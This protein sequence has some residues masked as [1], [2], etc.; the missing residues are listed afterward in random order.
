MSPVDE[1]GPAGVVA[2]IAN[3]AATAGSAGGIAAGEA[4]AAAGEVESAAELLRF[5]ARPE[6][7]RLWPEVRGRLERRGEA[8][9]T[10]RIDGATAAERRAVAGLLGLATVPEA[11][12]LRVRLER[13]DQALRA[14]RFAV[15]LAGAMALLGGPLRDRAAESARE[16]RLREEM[17]EGAAAH[18]A[19]QAR[20]DLGRWLEEL[21]AA[22]LV[23]R[24]ARAGEEARLL[25]RALDVL[26]AVARGR[27][28]MRLQVLASATLGASHGLDAGRPVASLVVRGLAFL[29]GQ[30]PP[31]GAAERRACWERAGV[32]VD[33]LSCNVLAL[34]VAPLGG[35]RAGDGLRTLAA[36]GEPVW[37]TLRQLAADDLAFPHGLVVRVCENPVVVAAAAGLGVAGGGGGPLVCTSGFPNQACRTLLALVARQ[38]GEVWYHGDFDWAGL[39]IA[40]TVFETVPFHPWRFTAAD[41]RRAAAALDRGIDRLDLGGPLA[42]AVW[43]ADL[44]SAMQEAGVAIE[45]EA[46]LTDLLEDWRS[47]L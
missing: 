29:D 41:Y 39:R 31:R 47:G 42:E 37:I 33:E 43:D 26:A 25:Q 24:L 40:N 36:A 32:I 17:W 18:A 6:L 7:A 16:R 34:G 45:E 35:G 21:R 2:G 44:G 8:R 11:G 12:D 19:V 1:G 14:S 22:G 23:R 27:G 10:V 46:L 15:D 5:L 30:P 20:P 9:G 4:S 38:G 28:E 3:S 13:L